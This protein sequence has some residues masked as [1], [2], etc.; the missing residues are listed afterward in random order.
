[1]SP[2]AS[3]D[4]ALSPWNSRSFAIS[5]RTLGMKRK[6]SPLGNQE[7]CQTK[8]RKELCGILRQPAVTHLPQGEHV[9]DEVEGMLDLGPD[10]GLDLLDLLEQSPALALWQCAALAR[11][12]GDVPGHLA[13]PVLFPLSTP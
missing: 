13:V 12:Q 4:F 2:S 3:A 10:A 9:L 7:I 6:Q 11:P 8:Q 5:G 1:M